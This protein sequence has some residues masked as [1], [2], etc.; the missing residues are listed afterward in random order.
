M[1][2]VF[3]SIITINNIFVKTSRPSLIPE[4]EK[5]AAGTQP[6]PVGAL[7]PQVADLR[8]RKLRPS[9]TCLLFSSVR[10]KFSSTGKNI[11]QY[12]KIYFS[13]LEN[14]L[15]TVYKFTGIPSG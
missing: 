14:L 3:C 10:N 9:G 6:V 1:Y 2:L 5:A 15:P 7:L 12:W 13:V 8:L 4:P 11:F